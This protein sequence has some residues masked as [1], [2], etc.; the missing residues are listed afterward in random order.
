MTREPTDDEAPADASLRIDKW[1]WYA[2]FYRSR[3][4]AQQAVAGG[5]VHVNGERAKPS[6]A[7]RIGDRLLI[8]RGDDR[9]EVIVRAIPLRRGPAPEAQ[10]HY[11]ETAESA[12]A[13]EYRRRAAKLAPAALPGRPDKHERRALRRLRGR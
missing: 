9:R 4:L 1:L 13:R 8:T 5:L 11:E 7:L 6:R 12:A 2:R 10:S 3:A